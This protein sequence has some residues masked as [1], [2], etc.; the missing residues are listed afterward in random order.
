[1]KFDNTITRLLGV[2]IPIVQAPM[3]W[4]A[5]SQLASA[6]SLAIRSTRKVRG[7][8]A[9]R[10]S[11]R[12]HAQLRC[13]KLFLV[14]DCTACLQLRLEPPGGIFQIQPQGPG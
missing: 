13:R 12:G 6:V 9:G 11:R 7:N 3:G 10:P 8:A 5:R 14:A 1:M 4:I 2:E